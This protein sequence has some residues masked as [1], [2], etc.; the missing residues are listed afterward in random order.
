MM[1]QIHYLQTARCEYGD[2]FW[3]PHGLLLYV[4]AHKGR[5]ESQNMHSLTPGGGISMLK[6]R[7]SGPHIWG[8][9]QGV[10]CAGVAPHLAP[11]CGYA[12]RSTPNNRGALYY[13]IISR[14]DKIIARRW[15]SEHRCTRQHELM[16]ER[17]KW[18]KSVDVGFNWIWKEREAVH[19]GLVEQ[20]FAVHIERVAVSEFWRG[21]DIARLSAP[22][23]LDLFG[24]NRRRIPLS[25]VGS[26]SLTAGIM[27]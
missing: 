23:S 1:L 18:T 8:L 24:F 22:R 4:A 11:S 6:K 9:G 10:V 26:L 13:L 17:K 2:N 25:D 12:R 15:K 20:I 16:L 21:G 27:P 5:D 19:V 7:W 3:F 14:P